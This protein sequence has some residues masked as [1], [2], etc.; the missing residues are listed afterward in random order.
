MYLYRLIQNLITWNKCHKDDM[1]KLDEN[2]WL[3]QGFCRII[4]LN[5]SAE[6][7]RPA[8]RSLCPDASSEVQ[9]KH[10]DQTSFKLMYTHEKGVYIKAI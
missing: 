8:G 6:A 5:L 4:S 7:I 1:L 2:G 3:W 9:G 10:N